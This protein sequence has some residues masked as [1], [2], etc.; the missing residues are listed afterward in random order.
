M[1]IDYNDL[2]DIVTIAS[3]NCRWLR[4]ERTEQRELIGW[5]IKNKPD[6]VEEVKCD[7]GY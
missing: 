5:F 4:L 6:L 7:G 2:W 3:D 1:E